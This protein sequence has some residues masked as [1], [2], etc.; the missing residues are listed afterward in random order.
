MGYSVLVYPDHL[1]DQLGPLTALMA[2]A[3][4]SSTLRVATYVLAN[5]FR[6]PVVMA[7]EAATLDVLSDGRFELGLGGGWLGPDYAGSGIQMDAPGIRVSRLIEAVQVIKGLFSDAPVDFS[8]TYYQVKGV[9]GTPKPVQRPYPPFFIGG[10]SRRIL[11]FAG[12]EADIVGLTPPSFGGGIDWSDVGSAS[13]AR[14]IEW[15]R[16]AAGDRF[17]A[18][19]LNTLVFKVVIT[20]HPRQAAEQ[21]AVSL[22]VTPEQVLESIQFLVGTVEGIC[23]EILMWRER[24]GISYVV[25]FEGDS[26][27]FGPVVSRLAGA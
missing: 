16:Q 9:Q 24:F 15:V 2:A 22:D 1:D 7:K 3:G 25:V 17:S 5:D 13:T 26:D 23:E 4:A 10:G 8:G 11:S 19:E 12:R 21:I 27:A 6:H 18:L 20:D 14:Q